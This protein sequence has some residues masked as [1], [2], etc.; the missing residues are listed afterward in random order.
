MD[1]N[2]Q[3]A[4]YI[5]FLRI[6]QIQIGYN[7]F[8]LCLLVKQLELHNVKIGLEILKV[9]FNNINNYKLLREY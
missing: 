9:K 8:L 7:S 4:K 2:F 1:L 6:L 5:K 3:L